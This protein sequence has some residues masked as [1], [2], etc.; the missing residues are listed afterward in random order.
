MTPHPPFEA[1]ELLP[2]IPACEH[3]AGSE[4]FIRKALELQKTSPVEFDL[5]LDL[6]DGAPVG[7]EA[8][9]LASVIA[10]LPERAPPRGRLGV[11]IHPYGSPHW[12]ND[13]AVVRERP[14]S[15]SYINIPKC[16]DLE[17]A[18]LATAA[19]REAASLRSSLKLHLMIETHGALRD[20]AKIAEL[21]QLESIDFGIMDF[22]SAHHGAISSDC[23][24]SP[25][26]FEHHLLVRAK[27]AITAAALAN[28]IIPTHNVTTDVRNPEK[29][30]QDARIAMER[31]GFLRMWS[32]H[33]SQIE[34]ITRGFQPSVSAIA[35]ARAILGRAESVQWAPIEHEGRLHDRA[36]YR[37]YWELV[38]RYE[39]GA[40]SSGK[41]PTRSGK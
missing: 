6:E 36:S 18:R 2:R 12:E 39:R 13:L 28:N 30:E 9:H 35:E 24:Q 15:I 4:R 17:S 11:R 5:T 19:V 7:N 20:V 25:L 14:H 22:I 27:A 37:Y 29:A 33:P 23:M 34:P 10:L 38:D 31:F 41:K 26:Q 40:A 21:P 3:I 32:V 1:A 8:S 16:E